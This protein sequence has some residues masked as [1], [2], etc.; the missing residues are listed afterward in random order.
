VNC[1]GV[2]SFK[3]LTVRGKPSTP[4]VI[5]GQATA[6]CA[7]TNGVAYSIPAVTGASTY[8]WT[9][10]LN[11]AIAGGQGTT[12]VTVNYSASFV[13]GTLSV[14]AGNACGAS[15]ARTLAISSLSA[16]PGTMAGQVNGVCA[17]TNGV[18]YSI[19]AVSGA[20]SYLWTA[21]PNATIASGQGTTAVTVNYGAAF[22]TGTL[23]VKSVNTCGMS[24]ARNVT[25]RSVPVTPGTITGASSVCANQTGVPFSIAA[26]TGATTY[27]WTVPAGATVATGQGTTSITVNFGS[28]AGSVKVRSGNACGY[29]TFKSKTV[30]ITCK[31]GERNELIERITLFP[32]PFTN[33]FTFISD[34]YISVLNIYDV[35]GRLLEVHESIMTGKEIKCGSLL[36]RGIYFVE[37]ISSDE[38][39]I[40]KLVKEN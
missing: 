34:G 20:F 28:S 24:G 27:N 15:A 30:S 26:V 22:T 19:A 23:S 13:S 36:S 4:G 40:V 35:S 11:A 3:S 6:V 32:N 7:G 29:S 12:S 31:T 16:T 1:Y 10:P 33:E 25:I 37:I 38:S 9:A 8:T 21:P 2:S 17:G 18:P 14:T 5:T 39:K